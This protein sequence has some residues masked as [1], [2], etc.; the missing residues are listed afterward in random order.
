MQIRVESIN[1]WQEH[2]MCVVLYSLDYRSKRELPAALR[3]TDDQE[4]LRSFDISF[5]DKAFAEHLRQAV[6]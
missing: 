5:S 1:P 2:D 3:G 6:E 4:R